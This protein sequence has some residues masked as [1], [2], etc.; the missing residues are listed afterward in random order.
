MVRESIEKDTNLQCFHSDDSGCESH[1]S[2]RMLPKQVESK[3]YCQKWFWEPHSLIFEYF[4]SFML[5]AKS[6]GFRGLKPEGLPDLWP[7]DT[8]L[9]WSERFFKKIDNLLV[10]S[11]KGLTFISS[12]QWIILAALFSVFKYHL[13]SIFVMQLTGTLSALMSS[14]LMAIFLESQELNPNQ[15]SSSSRMRGVLGGLGILFLDLFFIFF[16]SQARFWSERIKLRIQGSLTCGIMHSTLN[17]SIHGKSIMENS[18]P[19]SYNM[20]IVDVGAIT[21][22]IFA[23]L[24]LLL[25]P[26]SV[27]FS[28]IF[29][30]DRVSY[31]FINIYLVIFFFLFILCLDRKI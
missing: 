17:C 22:L 11:H 10:R 8:I 29:L 31:F 26:I 19:N 5:L 7:G 1:V 14:C 9:L 16:N 21:D 23:M 12:P 2:T 13:L 24:D 18:I 6:E 15:M 25:L 20:L 30:V 4:T 27:T 28:Y 3:K